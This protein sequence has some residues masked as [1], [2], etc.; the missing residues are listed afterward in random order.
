MQ[1]KKKPQR[2]ATRG[3]EI[4]EKIVLGSVYGIST[5]QLKRRGS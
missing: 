3:G 5:E 2:L 4:R 1:D